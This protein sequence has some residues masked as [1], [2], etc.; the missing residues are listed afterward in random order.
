MVTLPTLTL[1]D[2]LRPDAAI[3]QRAIAVLAAGRLIV[4]PTETVYGVAAD[5]HNPAAMARLYAAKGRDRDKPV[6]HLVADLTCAGQPGLALPPAAQ[7]LARRFCPGPITLVLPDG[8]GGCTGWRVP[9]HGVA[10]ALLK[11][12][13]GA[14]AVSSANLSGE[15]PARTAPEA[16]AALRGRVD[17]ILDAGPAPGGVPSTV[18]KVDWSGVTILRE[19]AISRAQVEDCL[20][21]MGRAARLW[22]PEISTRR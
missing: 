11:A 18:I 22:P 10:L 17:F 15:P 13:G 5:P 4:V 6:A 8:V 2:P 16:A 21:E 9:G 1:V 14:L 20:V 12:W 7:A 19:C 3:I